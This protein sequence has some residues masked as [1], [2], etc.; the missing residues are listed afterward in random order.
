MMQTEFQLVYNSS[1]KF[2]SICQTTKKY[3]LSHAVLEQ[4]Y[5]QVVEFA[6][7][8]RITVAIDVLD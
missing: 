2:R 7:T 6:L 4:R 5:Y 1:L 3:R 8:K